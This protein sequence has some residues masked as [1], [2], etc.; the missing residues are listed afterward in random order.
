MKTGSSEIMKNACGLTTNN[1]QEQRS[2]RSSVSWRYY[3]GG[4]LHKSHPA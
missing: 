4:Y 1:I 3:S 2:E